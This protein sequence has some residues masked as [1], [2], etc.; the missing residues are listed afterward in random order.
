M[1]NK[2]KSKYLLEGNYPMGIRELLHAL[3]LRCGVLLLQP[4]GL[5]VLLRKQS[6]IPVFLTLAPK[7]LITKATS[8]HKTPYGKQITLSQGEI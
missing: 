7:L 2:I 5:H 1:K 8:M 3:S 4:Q 6:I